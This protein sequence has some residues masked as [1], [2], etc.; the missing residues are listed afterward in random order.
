MFSIVFFDTLPRL[1]CANP[2]CHDHIV[3]VPVGIRNGTPYS[4]CPYQ[5][6]GELATIP[7]S[8]SRKRFYALGELHGNGFDCR[9]Y[10]RA[11]MLSFIDMLGRLRYKYDKILVFLDNA[12]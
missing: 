2:Q 1:S 10:D 6:H 9:F 11:N 5:F 3:R 12:G 4:L 8:L 7:V